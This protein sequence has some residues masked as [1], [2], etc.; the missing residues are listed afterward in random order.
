VAV[1]GRAR[2]A[3]TDRAETMPWGRWPEG[4]E[5]PP[6]PA[7]PILPHCWIV[8]RTFAWLGRYRRLSKDYEGVPASSGAM[9]DAA[10]LH[11]LAT[12][13]TREAA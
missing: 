12:E 10:P 6:M 1:A 8:E 13:P 3:A 11:A 2:P 9:L 5:P 4:V 7:F